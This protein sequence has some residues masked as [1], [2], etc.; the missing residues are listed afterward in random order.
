VNPLAKE[1]MEKIFRAAVAAVNPDMLI[2]KVLRSGEDGVSLHERGDVSATARWDEI[3][4]L[5]VVGGGKAARGMGEEVAQILGD[6]ATEGILAVP[7]GAGGEYGAIR[8]PEAGYPIPDEGSREATQSMM[9]L[10][11]GALKEDL[12]L[13]ILSGGGSS[14]ISATPADISI[15]EKER[16]LRLLL[17]AGADIREVNTVRR[18]ISLVKGGRMAE[19]A[20]PARVCLPTSPPDRFRLTPL[21]TRT[22][23]TFSSGIESCR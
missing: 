15:G 18:H 11:S 21:P 7:E 12:V 10:L 4:N 17:R 9:N 3:R 5:Y 14:M 1:Y 22:L 19:A 20:Y 23:S 8:F 2:R 6:R 16:V 13:A